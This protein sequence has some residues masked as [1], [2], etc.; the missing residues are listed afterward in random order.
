[1]EQLAKG[2][3]GKSPH[4]FTWEEDESP[5][6]VVAFALKE[7]GLATGRIGIEERVQFVFADGITKALPAAT[8]AS[9]TEITAGCRMIKSANEIEMMRLAN[10][11]TVEADD[12]DWKCATEG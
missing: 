2:P 12:A 6:K 8:I 5:Y 4:V 11:V 3:A 10:S 7:R 1:M 9:A